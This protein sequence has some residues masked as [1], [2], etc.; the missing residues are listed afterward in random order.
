MAPPTAPPTPPTQQQPSQGQQTQYAVAQGGA[1]QPQRSAASYPRAAT[2]NVRRPQQPQPQQYIYSQP[3]PPYNFVIPNHIRQAV[4]I[5]AQPYPQVFAQ[6]LQQFTYY[7]PAQSYQQ[8]AGP[9][10][11]GGQRQQPTTS[12]SGPPSMP[13]SNE[14]PSY[15]YDTNVMPVMQQQQQPAVPP[16]Q[17]TAK[18]SGS[19][20]LTIINPATGKSIFEDDSSTI[21]N[22][23]EKVDHKEETEKENSE[24][25]TP[26]VSAMS[27]GPS[28]DITPKHTVKIKK[29]K[30]PEAIPLLADPPKKIEPTVETVDIVSQDCENN[31]RSVMPEILT[32][33]FSSSTPPPASEQPMVVVQQSPQTPIP[34]P[35][36]GTDSN[37]T[38]NNSYKKVTADENQNEKNNLEEVNY[39]ICLKVFSKNFLFLQQPVSDEIEG[40]EVIEVP[41]DTNNNSTE[42]EV[43]QPIAEGAIDYDDDQWSPANTAGKKYY[44]RDQ[45]LKLKDIIPVPHLK[46]PEGV[47]NTLMKNNKECLTNTLNQTMPPMGMR[48]PFDAINSVA[49]KFMNNQLSGRNPYP[50]KRPSQQGM[51]QQVPGRGGSQSGSDRQIIKL[52]LSLQDNVKLNEAEN[53]WKPSHLQAKPE[54]SEEER[55]T[56]DVLSK[57]R[58]MLN[59]LT[60]ENFDVLVEQCRTFKIDTTERLDGVSFKKL[61]LLLF[62]DNNCFRNVFLLG[63]KFAF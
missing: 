7:P 37:D 17:K 25:L 23:K 56:F 20:A 53:A 63:Y 44:T 9:T 34:D 26:V 33:P 24:P 1:S 32:E 45:L 40:L 15:V 28:V 41:Q 46:L 58:S 22:D 2:S 50:N 55:Q 49:P 5:S 42:D 36:R 11:N 19:K 35:V 39:Y 48:Q 14:Y 30:P 54:F 52:H 59:K 47:A 13:T 12:S 16:P 38:N 4:P 57:F 27:D 21:S 51:K 18:K 6:Q 29:T 61:K 8:M 60:A 43:K 3:L 31:N 62:F 10:S